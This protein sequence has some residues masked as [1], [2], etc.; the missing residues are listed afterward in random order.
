MKNKKILVTS[1]GTQ[2][3]IDDFRILTNISSGMLGYLTAIKL[4]ETGAQ[5]FYVCSKSSVQPTCMDLP[6]GIR[7][8]R[9][10]NEAMEMMKQI[11]IE[12]KIDAVVHAMAVS[13]FTFKKDKDIKCKSSDPQAFIEYMRQTIVVN[14]KI[15]TMV[16][17]WRPETTLIG[18]K[19]EIGLTKD[20]LITLA[21]ASIEKN[22]CDLVIANDKKEMKRLGRHVAQFIHSEKMKNLFGCRDFEAYD[23][24]DIANKICS[25]LKKVL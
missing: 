2:E 9:T 10:V 25:F 4:A 17:Q 14:P 5:V 19:F 11:I 13:D 16:K 22:G 15:I 12:E 7:I 3:Y 20:E 1:G 6:M 18:F 24:D 8:I 21:Q 23:K